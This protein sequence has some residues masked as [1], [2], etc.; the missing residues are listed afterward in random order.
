MRGR[1]GPPGLQQALCRP[2]GPLPGLGGQRLPV[3]QSPNHTHSTRKVKRKS[4][5]QHQQRLALEVMIISH[6]HYTPLEAERTGAE[7][8]RVSKQRT[9]AEVQRVT[10]TQQLRVSLEG[11][12]AAIAV[13]SQATGI[14]GPSI[15]PGVSGSAWGGEQRV[16]P[17]AAP[18]P[19][20][21]RGSSTSSTNHARPSTGSSGSPAPNSP[22]A[23]GNSGCRRGALGNSHSALWRP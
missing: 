15:C 3:V 11:P 18:P 23:W 2:A 1:R 8:S 17:G 22:G 14:C 20:P 19:C 13:S 21:A 9:G 12:A 7:F 16:R 4:L 5:L 6:Q 10:Q